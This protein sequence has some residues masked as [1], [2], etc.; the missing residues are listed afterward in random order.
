[1]TLGPYGYAN[2]QSVR[3]VRSEIRRRGRLARK[4]RRQGRERD[5]TQDE[6][7]D[8]L[9][10]RSEKLETMVIY[11]IT[12]LDAAGGLEDGEA[13][14]ILKSFDEELGDAQ[15]VELED[16]TVAQAPDGAE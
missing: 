14:R 7:L 11:L 16:G 4:Y 12:R 1:M 2:A 5:D 3:E 6:R 9:E 13:A 15:L 8:A 10:E